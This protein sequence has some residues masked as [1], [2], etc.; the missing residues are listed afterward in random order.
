MVRARK[1][2]GHLNGDAGWFLIGALAAAAALGVLVT[3][4][5]ASENGKLQPVAGES[6]EVLE[7]AAPLEDPLQLV[8]SLGEQR[9]DVYRGTTLVESSKISSGK[10]GYSTPTGIFSI[11]EK[12]RRHFSNLYDDAP[13]PYM[14]RITW[15]GVALHQGYVPNYPASHGCIRLPGDFAPRLFGMTERGAHVLVMRDG[16][17]PKEIVHGSL[18]Q[19]FVPEATVASLDANT[20]GNDPALRGAIESDAVETS[21]LPRKTVKYSGKPLRILVTRASERARIRDMQRILHRLGYASGPV[22]G[23]FGRKTRAALETFQEGAR[24]PVT[25]VAS[26]LVLK[27]L[28]AAAGEDGPANGRVYVRQNFREIHSAP[29]RLKA[30]DEAIGT[31]IFTAL[32]FEDGDRETRWM[33]VSA[34]ERSDI[35]PEEALDRVEWPE[36]VRAYLEERLTPGS[37]LIV[38][39]RGFQRHS[40][41]GTDFI[42]TTR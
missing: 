19:S 26:D 1:M 33:V 20:I 24:L 22:D 42:V 40:G 28:Y 36:K 37:S 31:H 32:N 6:A 35:L 29:V 15:S 3:P 23:V 12:R 9:I 39:D 7:D 18:L 21:A 8:V 2:G 16:A 10:S 4:A 30:P 13:M 17:A 25:G 41:L 38:T 5:K 27:R 34:D 14:Q 11:L